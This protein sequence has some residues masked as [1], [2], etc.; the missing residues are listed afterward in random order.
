MARHARFRIVEVKLRRWRRNLPCFGLVAFLAGR[1]RVAPAQFETRLLVFGQRICR[2]LKPVFVVATLATIAIRLACELP[3]VNI[4][5]AIDANVVAHSIDGLGSHRQMALGA[6]HDGVFTCQRVRTLLVTA[7]VERRGL[8]ALLHMAGPAVL[9]ELAGMWIVLPVAI[10]ACRMCDRFLEIRR[11]VALEAI[12]LG[13]FAH[14]CESRAA[15]IESRRHMDALPSIGDV[16]TLALAWKRAL[17]R[18]AVAIVATGKRNIPE[19]RRGL[20]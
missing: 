2:R 15:V 10:R 1:G 17:M 20:L 6:C 12:H 8:V 13:V 16:T 19:P 5:V 3:T 18:I 4:L 9:F 14:Q 11:T 7:D